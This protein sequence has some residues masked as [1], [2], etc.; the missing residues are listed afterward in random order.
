MKAAGL[1]RI[2][3]ARQGGAS[4]PIGAMAQW[5]DS[6][7]P[8]MASAMDA[9]KKGTEAEFTQAKTAV[10]N[11]ENTLKEALVP[12]AKTLSILTEN[13]LELIKAADDLIKESRPGYKEMLQTVSDALTSVITEGE[14]SDPKFAKKIEAKTNKKRGLGKGER[15]PAKKPLYGKN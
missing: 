1:N 3:A 15:A 7:G 5:Q 2:L 4:T 14:K 12:G 6:S 13:A 11:T 8:A 10:T 9:Y